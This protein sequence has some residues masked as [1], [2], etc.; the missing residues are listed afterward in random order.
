[1][2]MVVE[3]GAIGGDSSFVGKVP[4]WGGGRLA[5]VDMAQR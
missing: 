5:V 4:N 3:E 2:G 1:M